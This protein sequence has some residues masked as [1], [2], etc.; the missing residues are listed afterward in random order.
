MPAPADLKLPGL[1]FKTP[2]AMTVK[3]TCAE[4]PPLT[5]VAFHE[6]VPV[7]GTKLTE[8]LVSLFTVGELIVVTVEELKLVNN[9]LGDPVENPLP[10]RPSVTG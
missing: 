2:G 8:I 5:T 3:G 6:L 9:T 1:I 7:P 10:V 4:G